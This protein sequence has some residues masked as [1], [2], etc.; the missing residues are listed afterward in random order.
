MCPVSEIRDF[1]TIKVSEAVF[2]Y[3][4]FKQNKLPSVTNS[5]TEMSKFYLNTAVVQFWSI[6]TD[7]CFSLRF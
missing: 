4:I 1:S 5:Q 2:K 7:A 3:R 6:I